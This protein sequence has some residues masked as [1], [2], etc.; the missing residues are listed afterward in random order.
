MAAAAK[1]PRAESER[2]TGIPVLGIT[3]TIF[4]VLM[5]VFVSMV[6]TFTAM[7][8]G[9]SSMIGGMMGNTL[10]VFGG[11]IAVGVGILAAIEFAISWALFSG[12][13]AGRTIVI[14]LS[15]VDFIIHCVTL[16][17]G[18]VFAIPHIALD[19]IT[20]FY[21]WKPSVIMYYDRKSMNLV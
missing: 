7:M 4:G 15:M 5:I 6:V 19:L 17:V 9:Y 16:L 2:P 12:K 11:F 21:M 1:T 18:N 3:Y 13:N 14:V 8:G 10:T 20:F